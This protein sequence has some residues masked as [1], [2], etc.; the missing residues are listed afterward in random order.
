MLNTAKLQELNQY[1]AILVAGE[2]KN[3]DKIVTEYALVYKDEV[4]IIGEKTTFA[5]R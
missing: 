5:K 3:A 4:I 2:V 1:G